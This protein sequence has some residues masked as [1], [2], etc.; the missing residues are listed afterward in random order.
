MRKI[1]AGID[2]EPGGASRHADEA[3]TRTLR[4]SFVTASEAQ[5]QTAIA[6][7]AAAIRDTG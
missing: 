1:G 2:G 6:A 3:D 7:L 4:L 5:I